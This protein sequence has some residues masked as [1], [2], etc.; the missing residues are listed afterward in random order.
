[1]KGDFSIPP[2]RDLPPHRLAQRREHLSR[3]SLSRPRDGRFHGVGCWRSL[4]QL[5]SSWSEQPLR[6]AVFAPSSSIRASS[7]CRQRERRRARQRAASSSSVGWG[8][9][10]TLAIGSAPCPRLGVRRR[11][12]HLEPERAG[13]P[14]ARTSSPPATSSNDSRPRVSSSC[15]RRSS[16]SSKAVA[17]HLSP[18]RPTTIPV[19]FPSL[20][21]RDGDR[22]VRLIGEAPT[23]RARRARRSSSRLSGG[24][25]RLLTDPASV[26]PSSAWAVRE[27]RAYV[28]SHYAVCIDT[29]PPKDASQLLSLL[30]TRAADLL[31]D[32]S[33]TSSRGRRASPDQVAGP[34]W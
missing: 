16:D 5:S 34:W 30:P 8:G 12:N 26:L 14:R 11:P 21:V 33:R 13:F 7:V 1:M 20:E 25:T 10:A 32:K 27:V 19:G 15:G 17:L 29:A 4:R 18:F 9:A 23:S 31:R 2:P 6:S 24:S 3:R 28:P 22:L